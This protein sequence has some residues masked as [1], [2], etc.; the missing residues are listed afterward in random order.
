M[1]KKQYRLWFPEFPRSWGCFS[2][3]QLLVCLAI[4]DWQLT[5]RGPFNSLASTSS[6]GKLKESCPVLNSYSSL[7]LIPYFHTHIYIC[8]VCM[9]V[10]LYTHTFLILQSGAVKFF[11]LLAIVI[12]AAAT[13]SKE[14]WEWSH[15]IMCSVPVTLL[16][17][18][19][20]LKIRRVCVCGPGL[21]SNSS[22]F[23]VF[24]TWHPHVAPY[25][26][27]PQHCLK[28]RYTFQKVKHTGLSWAV[29]WVDTHVHVTCTH[30]I[31]ALPLLQKELSCSF[32]INTSPPPKQTVRISFITEKCCL[33]LEPFE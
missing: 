1:P 30:I 3:H 14:E 2:T 4:F 27:W 15:V 16:S 21:L 26:F 7:I 12:C 32:P 13:K 19:W 10:Y 8:V 25:L 9:C 6:S 20:G 24:V 23:F 17:V 5:M 18:S 28:L 29:W 33:L 31:R 22:W 11:L